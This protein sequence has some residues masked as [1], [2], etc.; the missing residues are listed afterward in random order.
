ML[1]KETK[2]SMLEFARIIVLAIIPVLLTYFETPQMT[3]KAL[4]ISIIIA[5]LKAVDKYMH[6]KGKIEENDKLVKGLT[7]F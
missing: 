7:R 2:E 4:A 1:N 3:M 5:S 6:E